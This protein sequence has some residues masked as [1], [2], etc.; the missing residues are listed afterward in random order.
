C[1]DD[2]DGSKVSGRA[3]RHDHGFQERAGRLE[4][5]SSAMPTP[6]T[7]Y[8]EL[9]TKPPH[10]ACAHEQIHLVSEPAAH[11]FCHLA[12]SPARSTSLPRRK[13]LLILRLLAMSSSGLASSTT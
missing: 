9:T 7:A 11:S 1:H 12:R 3:V 4:V 5:E 8:R 13:T 6:V 10:F 2:R